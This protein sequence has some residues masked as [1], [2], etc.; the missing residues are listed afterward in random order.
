M[1]MKPLTI[2]DATE[3]WVSRFDAVKQDMIAR[4]MK[5]EPDTWREVTLP[6]VGDTAYIHATGDCGEII[7]HDTE[8]GD[9]RIKL[10]DGVKIYAQAYDFEVLYDY[11]LPM[12]GTMWSFDDSCDERWLAEFGGLELMSELGFRIYEHDDFGYYFGIDGAG[13]DFYEA[14]WIPLYRA[15][16]LEWHKE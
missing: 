10:A 15:R 11:A 3:L 1:L 8:S 6:A 5:Y 14:H 4:L 9:Y 7:E 16:G 12:W 13:Y 2:K